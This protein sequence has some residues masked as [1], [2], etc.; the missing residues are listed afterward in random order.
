M[1]LPAN[2]L[3]AYTFEVVFKQLVIHSECKP[4][5]HG[6]LTTPPAHQV[7]T[8]PEISF[9]RDKNSND[10]YTETKIFEHRTWSNSSSRPDNFSNDSL[11]SLTRADSSNQPAAD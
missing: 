1:Y 2:Q 10:L 4:N 9:R 5:K 8:A 3:Q 7:S 11:V 6:I